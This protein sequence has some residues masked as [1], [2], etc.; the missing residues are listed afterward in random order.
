[1]AWSVN[2]GD[3]V[4]SLDWSADGGWLAV[5][6]IGGPVWIL[7]GRTGEVMH[8]LAGHEGG[9]F[10]VAFSPRDSPLASSGQDGSVKL[11]QPESGA[12]FKSLPSGAA[13][14]EHLQWSAS[15]ERLASGAGRLL[16]LWT[17]EGNEALVLP[18]HASTIAGLSWRPDGRAIAAACYGGVQLWDVSTGNSTDRLPWKT[19]LISVAWSPDARWVVAGT[20]ELAVQIWELPFRPGKELAMSGY[21]SKVR[22]LAWH[23]SSRYLATGGSNE[24]MVWDFIG[25]GPAGTTPRILEGHASRVSALQ[26]QRRGHWLASGCIGGFVNFW[27]AGRDTSSRRR[28]SLPAE[29]TELRWSPDESCVAAGCHDGTVGVCLPP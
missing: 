25:K 13:W 12:L 23:Y 20:Q 7:D 9:A 14:T 16:K 18:A 24:I 6:L 21:S 26:Y 27:N 5:A 3:H 2:V 17:P 1:V 15:G 10:R 28:I 19:S 22:E 11:W 4:Q 29:I 8:R